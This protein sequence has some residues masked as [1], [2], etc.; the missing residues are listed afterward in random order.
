ME[1]NLSVF[2]LRVLPGFLLLCSFGAARTLPVVLQKSGQVQTENLPLSGL[3]PGHQY[4]ILYSLDS[5]R[6][7]RPDSRINVEVRQGGAVLVGKV[8]HAG[9]ADLYAQFR[10]VESGPVSVAVQANDANGGYH[11]QVNR[12]PPSP[13]LKS[14]PSHRW[15]R[16]SV[17]RG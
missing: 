9:D 16:A 1:P 11:L 8:L 2:R 4:S 13:E 3:Q 15:K 14:A 12:W 17:A 5:L 7:L 10:V 6:D